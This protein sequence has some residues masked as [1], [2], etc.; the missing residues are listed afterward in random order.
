M[1]KQ[2]TSKNQASDMLEVNGKRSKI[3]VT[4]EKFD[5][6]TSTLLYETLN[7]TNEAIEV[8]KN[9]G[10]QKIDEI[11]LVGG[12]TRMP[13]V[14]SMLTENFKESEIKILEPDEA[15]AKGAAIHAVNVYVNNQKSLAGQDF[16]SNEEV[17]VS[18]N[19]D[20]KELNA[21]DYKEDLSVSPEMMSIGGAARQIVIATTKSFALKII[22]NNEE[23]CY[24]MI[25]K[26]EPMN[27]GFVDVSKVF[28]TLYY[29][30]GSV[31]IEIY[32]NDYMDEYFNVDDDLKIGEAIL[33]L[34]ARLPE[35]APIEVTLKLNKEGILD[36]KGVDKTGNREVNVRMETKGVMSEE[37]LE[38]IKR[39]SQGIV[40]L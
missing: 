9:K 10:Y 28:G 35:G 30:Q 20:E 32:E 23:K 2:L 36:V 25:V 1:K 21:S 13:Q 6:I 12:S 14:K 34:P 16:N 37:E 39:R 17:K 15:V 22:H 8:A 5:E 38:K 11:L 26:N 27:N 19:G 31:N 24:N 40:V 18:V 4:R 29:D 33:E 3:T 7:K